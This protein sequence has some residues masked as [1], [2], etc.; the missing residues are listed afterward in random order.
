VDL[1]LRELQ[2]LLAVADEHSFTAAGQRL[3]L[4]Q[5]SVSALI[6]RLELHLG[7][8]LFERTTRRVTPTAACD[9][10]V[11]SVRA[12]LGLLDDAVGHARA[13]ARQE[14]P[15]RLAFT[16]ATSFGPLQ[17]L[18]A[19][20]ADLGLPDPDVRELWADEVPAAVRDGRFHAAVGVEVQPEPGL[21]VRPWRRHRVDLLVAAS[22][23]FAALP[24]V[25]VAQLA[26]TS[27]VMPER[28]T[29]AGLHDKLAATLARA[30]VSM[31]VTSA[32]RVSG[33]APPGVESGTA[34]TVWLDGMEE[35]YVP[36]GLVHVPLGEPATIV[37]VNLVTAPQ[38]GPSVP[39][40]LRLLHEAIDQT[41][42]LTALAD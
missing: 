13:A 4:T 10:L 26:G 2:C 30:K 11:P 39:I 28:L 19:A 31:P 12:A 23:P 1:E 41:A 8:Q 3:H 16:P 18:L 24:C 7:V 40:G 35:R 20:L 38:G 36:A 14:P 15:L 22:H 32:P 33:P 21:S 6:R 34:A 29:N 37:A 25:R 5:Q 17:I 9:A 42:E 27:L